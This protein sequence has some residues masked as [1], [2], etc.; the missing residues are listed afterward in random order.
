MPIVTNTEY[1]IRGRKRQRANVPH[2][3]IGP[4]TKLFFA[5]NSAD[6]PSSDT[7]YAMFYP[8]PGY[9]ATSDDHTKRWNMWPYE[10][11]SLMW[12]SQG[13][14]ASQRIGNKISAKLMR[15]K[16]VFRVYYNLV[17]PVRI[18]LY[19]FFY[20]AHSFS[21]TSVT[22]LKDYSTAITYTSDAAASYGILMNNYYNSQ[23]RDAYL[24]NDDFFKTKVG[25]WYIRPS[26]PILAPG[27]LISGRQ[28]EVG[29]SGNVVEGVS[30]NVANAFNTCAYFIPF[31]KTVYLNQ[32]VLCDQDTHY[33]YWEVDGGLGVANQSTVFFAASVAPNAHTPLETVAKGEPP[34]ACQF[35]L[36]YYFQDD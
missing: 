22:H 24:N 18:R 34:I 11:R 19:Y 21:N 5:I 16:G 30:W 26:P 15:F 13:T 20:K 27:Q 4:E 7:T 1:K 29:E 32:E 2:K 25:E 28:H 12:P 8:H 36:F 9:Y 6:S 17:R 35:K 10:S 33:L 3:P 14:G 23:W 31:D